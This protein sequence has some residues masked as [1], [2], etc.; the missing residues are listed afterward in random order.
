M[1]KPRG[2][3]T[4]SH[5]RNGAGSV[6]ETMYQTFARSSHRAPCRATSSRSSNGTCR[7]TRPEAPGVRMLKAQIRTGR[8]MLDLARPVVALQSRG[9]LARIMDSIRWNDLLL[10]DLQPIRAR[11]LLD[12][13]ES[14]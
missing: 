12:F 8:V 7:S 5:L 9:V 3:S 11:L 6:P 1:E 4:S 2:W 13:L 14:L 10:T